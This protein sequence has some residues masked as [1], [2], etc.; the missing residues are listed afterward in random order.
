MKTTVAI[1]IFF[2]IAVAI[3]PF[4]HFEE[5]ATKRSAVVTSNFALYDISK[6]LLKEDVKVTMLMPAGVDLHTFEP[7]PKDVMKIKQSDF[8]I[9]SGAEIEHYL[10]NFSDKNSLDMSKNVK[11][12]SHAK[13]DEH[14]HNSHVDPHYWLDISNMITMTQHLE[15]AYANKYIEL[16]PKITERAEAY[17]KSLQEL[18]TL[19]KSKLSTC[20]I[21]EII[22]NHNAY[23]YLAQKY[24]FRVE[25]LSGLSSDAQVNAKHMIALNKEIHSK[26]ITTLFYD[27]FES[28][29]EIKALSKEA[30]IELQTLHTLA[31]VTVE[32]FDSNTTYIE[33]MQ[34]N[35][36]KLAKAMVC[37]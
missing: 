11:L 29:N 36:E 35:V 26:H 19:Y 6:A 27:S 21:D 20:K 15:K 33:L 12:L 2:I 7:T 14:H 32:E 22:V 31:N 24:G 9:Y 34:E 3:F 23:A 25:A 5:G 28:A 16:V 10:E 17:I 1:F 4:L 18:E 13:D 37:E 8:F 30:N